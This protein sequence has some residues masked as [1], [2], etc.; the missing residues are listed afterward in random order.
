M[1]TSDR[2]DRWLEDRL[3]QAVSGGFNSLVIGSGILNF[4][5]RAHMTRLYGQLA[6]LFGVFVIISLMLSLAALVQSR[7]WSAALQVAAGVLGSGLVFVAVLL[8]ALPDLFQCDKS[9]VRTIIVGIPAS[10]AAGA[11]LGALFVPRA[12]A[13]LATFALCCAALALWDLFGK[14]VCSVD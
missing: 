2:E 10:L 9:S 4:V 5:G 6:G 7:S 8:L 1:R 3:P 12:R 14:I 13:F 11:T